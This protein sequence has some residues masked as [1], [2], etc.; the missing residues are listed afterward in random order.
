MVGLKPR[1]PLLYVL[2]HRLGVGIYC[3]L[4]DRQTHVGVNPVFRRIGEQ[5][6]PVP[7]ETGALRYKKTA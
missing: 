1:S 2:H 3:L 6:N 4:G 7:I 5:G